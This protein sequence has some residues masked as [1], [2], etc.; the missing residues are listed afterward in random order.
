LIWKRLSHD[1]NQPCRSLKGKAHPSLARLS[2][3]T[4]EE[5]EKEEQPASQDSLEKN[6][7]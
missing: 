2:S 3:G 6:I 7:K 1:L 5:E 4:E